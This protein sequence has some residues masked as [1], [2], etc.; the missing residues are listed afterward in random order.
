[1]LID[2][3]RCIGCEACSL[4]C[5]Q[6]R[7]TRP[8]VRRVM[9]CGLSGPPERIRNFLPLSC[10]NCNNPPCVE[11]CPTGATYKTEDGIVDIRA[12]LCLGC[13]YCVLACPYRARAI[14]YGTKNGA[15]D[16]KLREKTG[17][18]IKCNF[19]MERVHSG[20]KIG[21]VPG[22]HP[23]A[24]PLCVIA[25]SAGALHFGDINDP[26]SRI[27]RLLKENKAVCLQEELGTLPSVFYIPFTSEFKE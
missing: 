20:L 17:T 12:D 16:A 18:C 9:D 10:M 13:G 25:C 4:V 2:L 14:F 15:S 24:T 5:E 19:C 11:A 22:T 6:K 21:L 3:R 1:M 8:P 27:S 23:E 7:G 26:A